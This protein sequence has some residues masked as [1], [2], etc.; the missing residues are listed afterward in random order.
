MAS[1]FLTRANSSASSIVETSLMSSLS[2]ILSGTSDNSRSFSDG[3]KTISFSGNHP[4]TETQGVGGSIFQDNTGA[5]SITGLELDYSFK[6]P[7]FLYIAIIKKRIFDVG[8]ELIKGGSTC[9]QRK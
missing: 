6:F 9:I 1:G 5:I 4:L 2:L 7:I 8:I 3:I